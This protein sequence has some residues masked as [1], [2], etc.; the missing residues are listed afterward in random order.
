MTLRKLYIDNFFSIDSCTVEFEDGVTIVEGENRDVLSEDNTSNGAGKTAVFNAI[1]QCLYDKNLKSE[2]LTIKDVSNNVTGKPYM[3]ELILTGIDGNLYTILN[4]RSRTVTFIFKNI[5]GEWIDITPKTKKQQLAYIEQNITGL[6][7]SSFAL[8]LYNN[9]N[10]IENIVN[11]H[12]K[13]G[14]L[15]TLLNL[16]TVNQLA[17]VLADEKT[18]YKNKLDV[19]ISK[20]VGIDNTLSVDYKEIDTRPYEAE[21]ESI[22]KEYNKFKASNNLVELIQGLSSALQDKQSIYNTELQKLN[23]LDARIEVG[24]GIINKLKTGTCPVC[25]SDVTGT[26]TDYEKALSKLEN[27]RE[28]QAG[29]VSALKN[30]LQDIETELKQR[31]KD[32]DDKVSYYKETINSLTNKI[33]NAK[34]M[35]EENKELL[36][37]RAKLIKK[38]KELESE[39]LFLKKRISNLDQLHKYIRSGDIE[40]KLLE[41]FVAL[42]TI[43]AEELFKLTANNFIIH[44]S[45]VNKTIKLDFEVNGSNRN[46]SALSAGERLRVNLVLLFAVHNVLN[47]LG[48]QT[49]NVIVLDEILGVFDKEGI[50]FVER[51]LNLQYNKAIYLINHNIEMN[52][53]YRVLKI[54]KENGLS[55]C[56]KEK[57]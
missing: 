51:L 29:V 47:T 25:K 4:D 37:H 26:V 6:S 28:R 11:L 45:L 13:G 16:E 9:P 24:K 7:F 53:N 52:S 22:E 17:T 44:I 30:E 19:V 55:R 33:D 2:K 1:L 15:N 20:L 14:L 49:P 31:R 54:I 35:N 56:E 5:D 41:H 21:L 50:G 34:Q 40:S 27:A 18:I 36:K 10:T 38:K 8:M 12:K 3:L 43:K 23:K 46:Y 39:E 42:L 32:Y 48:V 57:G